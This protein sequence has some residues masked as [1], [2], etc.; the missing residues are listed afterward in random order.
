[1]AKFL[2]L[3]LLWILYEIFFVGDIKTTSFFLFFIKILQFFNIIGLLIFW[4]KCF[5]KSIMSENLN[6]KF[7]FEISV[8]TK[9][10][11]D[12]KYTSLKVI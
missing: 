7:E 4:Y 6:S 11:N 5:L 12:L 9:S 10:S 8:E 1:M 2:I 3:V